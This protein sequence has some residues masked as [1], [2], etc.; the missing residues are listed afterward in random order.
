MEKV[1]LFYL[2][3][4]A[5]FRPRFTLCDAYA[6][7]LVPNPPEFVVVIAGIA[8][9]FDELEYARSQ[10]FYSHFVEFSRAELDL[11]ELI[12]E[13]AKKVGLFIEGIL[14]WL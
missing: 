9:A 6:A 11:W 2:F 8:N 4:K 1:I 12:R 3:L 7:R 14:S 10:I 5:V 13:P